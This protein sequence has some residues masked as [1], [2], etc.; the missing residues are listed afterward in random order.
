MPP[1]AGKSVNV[2]FGDGAF[3]TGTTDMNGQVNV[4]HTYAAAGSYPVAAT[5]AGTDPLYFRE[6]ACSSSL[7]ASLSLT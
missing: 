7:W 2:T 3:V 6:G 4:T 5:F 1:L